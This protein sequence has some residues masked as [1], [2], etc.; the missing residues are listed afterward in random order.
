MN[1]QIRLI[2]L[3]P[4]LEALQKFVNDN[5]I[6]PRNGAMTA[7]EIYNKFGKHNT[8]LDKDDFI[9]AFRFAI[10]EGKITGI[11]GSGKG[12]YKRADLVKPRKNRSP[13]TPVF[14]PVAEASSDSSVEEEEVVE[15]DKVGIDIRIGSYRLVPLDKRNWGL[16]KKNGNDWITQGYYSKLREALTGVASKLIDKQLK[17]SPKT[18]KELG[19]LVSLIKVAEKN[20]ISNME[21]MVYEHKQE[22]DNA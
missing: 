13:R 9:Q 18:I 6:T 8:S 7:Q 3:T 1:N 2:K 15:D 16:Q 21:K 10:H 4:Q 22:Q 19:E 11:A 14:E 20:L 5:I 12:G 17:S